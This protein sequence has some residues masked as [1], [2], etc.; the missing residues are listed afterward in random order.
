MT[1]PTN[2]FKKPKDHNWCKYTETPSTLSVETRSYGVRSYDVY[3][4]NNFRNEGSKR[5]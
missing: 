1:V 3:N 2:S 5:K 4:Q